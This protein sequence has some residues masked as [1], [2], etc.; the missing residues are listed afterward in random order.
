MMS[1][2]VGT[3]VLALPFINKSSGILVL[4]ITLII[5]AVIA[6]WTLTIL[7]NASFETNQNN[8]AIV[9]N[10]ILG[11]KAGIALHII[12]I[13]ACFGITT[14]YI[15]TASSFTPGVLA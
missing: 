3:G 1:T 5:G 12:F 10:K 8:Y 11:K 2:A 15:I 4:V 13:I 14:I 9:V 6:N 7:M